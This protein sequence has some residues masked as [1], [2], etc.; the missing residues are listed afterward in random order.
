MG[1]NVETITTDDGVKLYYEVSGEGTPMVFVHEFAGDYRSFEPQMRHFARR[2]RCI[3]YNARGYPPSDVPEAVAAYSQDRARDDILAVL[4][5]L[6]IERAHIVGVSMGSLATLHFGLHYPD[7]ALSLT[8]GGCGYGAPL[9]EQ[10]KFRT[11]SGSFA[12]RIEAEGMASVAAEYGSG[13][14]RVQFENKDPRGYAEFLAMLAEHSS[15]G[16]VNTLRGVQMQRPS[17]YELEASLS[18]LKVPTLIMAG[19]EDEPCLDASLYLK[20]TIP[21]AGFTLLPK[22]GHALN[23]EEPDLFNRLLDDFVHQVDAGRWTLRDPRS[24]ADSLLSQR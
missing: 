24:V 12:A 10:E 7:R 3:A 16:S 11:E 19:D 22:T 13:P 17:V 2:Y 21:S 1:D 5:G 6:A 4:D 15:L 8:L 23:L 18:Q 14:S 9:N 20:R